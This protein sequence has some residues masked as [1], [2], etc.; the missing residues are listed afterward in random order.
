MSNSRSCTEHSYAN[1]EAERFAEEVRCPFCHIQELE[2]EVKILQR[3]NEDQSKVHVKQLREMQETAE[4]KMA[5]KATHVRRTYY[6]ITEL[7]EM[8]GL[9]QHRDLAPYGK[10]FAA[11]LTALLEKHDE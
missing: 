11:E 5:E 10:H 1:W 4:S 2:A 7:R 8:A 6:L 9:W 3:L